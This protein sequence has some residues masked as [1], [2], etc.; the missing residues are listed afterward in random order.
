[1]LLRLT[2]SCSI[3]SIFLLA[4]ATCGA[5]SHLRDQQQP[6]ASVSFPAIA[7]G[8]L[9]PGSRAVDELDLLE[10]EHESQGA[11]LTF[12]VHSQAE[13]DR[14][15]QLD[16]LHNVRIDPTADSAFW[17]KNKPFG[18]DHK[19]STRGRRLLTGT[20]GGYPCFRNVDASYA[21]MDRLAAQYPTLATVQDIGDSYLKTKGQGGYDI[22]VLK[23]TAPNRKTS[24]KGIMFAM[25]GIHV[26]EMAP[27]ELGMR[28][29]E[30]LLSGY[31]VDPEVTAVLEHTEIHLVLQA[32]PD[33]RATD[34]ARQNLRRKNMN[35]GS[36]GASRC[37]E[38][39][40]GVDLNRNFP[41]KWG[42]E[43]SSSDPCSQTFRG[44]APASEPE[45]SAIVNY[46]ESIFPAGQRKEHP[47]DLEL[48]AAYEDDSVGI[49]FDVHAYGELNI[50]PWSF[51]N[52]K[53]ANDEQLQTLARKYNS[54]NNH[55][56]AGPETAEFLYMSSGVT[57][58]YAYGE[59]GVSSE[60]FEL[61]TAFYQSCS[62]FEDTIIPTNLPA[63]LYGAKVSKAPY[64]TPLGPDVI[65][66]TSPLS[67]PAIV[68]VVPQN[69]FLTVEVQVSDSERS[70]FEEGKGKRKTIS[71]IATGQQDV[72]SVA[73]FIDGH[74]EDDIEQPPVAIRLK[75]VDGAYN[76]PSET[77]SSTID[78]SALA[79]GRHVLH[80]QATDSDGY[81]GPVT[82]RYF[83]VSDPANTDSGGGIVIADPPLPPPP[84]QCGARGSSCDAG[85]DCCSGNCKNG[86]CKGG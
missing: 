20:I 78:L 82:S 11:K 64:R 83:E 8:I 84:P 57:D 28:F 53:S 27:P 44:T 7:I 39:G 18:R 2:V 41:F 36:G 10:S 1:M 70:S 5:A 38:D 33:A 23:I 75:P 66:L 16:G 6:E 42:G 40:Y 86:S 80:I 14:V 15:S 85:A 51:V 30:M 12:L 24:S 54:F 45:V 61:G 3:L 49:F 71:N 4:T 56:L 9:L 63:L 13:L 35:P 22:K 17:K 47:S 52:R 26:R 48:D 72:A 21:L 32:N 69:Q 59:L 37:G 43:G 62:Y 19:P 31:D 73:V 29:A 50:Y 67:D 74:P 34:E 60:T 46:C 77:A 81:A 76:S 58:E 68:P 25:F 79:V 55:A 65:S